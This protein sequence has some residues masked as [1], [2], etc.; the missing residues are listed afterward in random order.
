MLE[1]YPRNVVAL[2]ARLIAI[3]SQSSK[4]NAPV[5]ALLSLWF[6]GYQ[7]HIHEWTR[8]KDGIKGKNL[9]VKI[10]GKNSEKSLVFLCHMDTVPPSSA[11]ETDPFILEEVEGKLYGLGACDTKGGVASL[12]QAVFSLTQQPAVDTYLVFDGDEESTWTGAKSFHKHYAL[13]NPTF[14][15]VEPT[16]ATL[17]LGARSILECTITTNGISTHASFG[18][19]ELNRKKNAIYKM[20]SIL[21][22]LIE[23]AHV[24]SQEHD[25]L[26]GSNSQNIGMILGGTARN[27]LPDTCTMT[28]DR[29]LLPTKDMEQELLFLKEMIQL[30]DPHATIGSVF[31]Q[32]GFRMN[33]DTKEIKQ[34]V[35]I[36][37]K[38]LPDI[39]AGCFQAMSEVTLFQE[40]GDCIVL[41][42]GSI[43]LAHR[44][45]EYVRSKELFD[46]V[47]IYRDIIEAVTL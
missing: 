16:D 39:K 43:S 19:P 3:D 20:N 21:N 18:T 40:M 32:K 37:Q 42:P 10:P 2:L 45:N 30:V 27:V 33:E 28:L 24:L 7:T 5:I 23:D 13:P 31:Y 47:N 26:M 25:A 35:K 36:I 11:W 9:I 22:V 38:T 17:C 15:A 12:I 14:I 4:D 1:E 29:R 6:A 44:A 41:G 34:M 8:E 46:Y